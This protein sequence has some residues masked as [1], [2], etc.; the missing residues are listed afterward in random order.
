MFSVYDVTITCNFPTAKRA[1]FGE[2]SSQGIVTSEN[3]T[4]LGWLT[5]LRVILFLVVAALANKPWTSYGKECVIKNSLF[6]VELNV[7]NFLDLTKM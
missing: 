4:R 6:F 2:L 5:Q 7:T 3:T 1:C